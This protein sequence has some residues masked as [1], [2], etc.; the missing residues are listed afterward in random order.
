MV[1]IPPETS[2]ENYDSRVRAKRNENKSIL[3]S[4]V[5]VTSILLKKKRLE[6]A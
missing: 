1:D 4:Y 2:I 6:S 5:Y 3:S